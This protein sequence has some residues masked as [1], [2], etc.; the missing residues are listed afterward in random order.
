MVCPALASL[1]G[2]LPLDPL[3]PPKTRDE[4]VPHAP[5]RNHSLSPSQKQVIVFPVTTFKVL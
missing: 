5:K 3:P 4:A 1:C 2:G